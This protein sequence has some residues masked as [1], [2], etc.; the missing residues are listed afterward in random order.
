MN[1]ESNQ[2]QPIAENPV[3]QPSSKKNIIFYTLLAILLMASLF[4]WIIKPV[5]VKN[6]LSNSS[7]SSFSNYLGHKTINNSEIIKFENEKS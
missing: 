1:E 3:V 5:W 7:N 6:L 4:V 2:Q